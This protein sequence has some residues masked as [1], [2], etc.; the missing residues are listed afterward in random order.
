MSASFTQPYLNISDVDLVGIP[1]RSGL[2]QKA[3]LGGK[4]QVR[5]PSPFVYFF[6][7]LNL[8]WEFHG[9]ECVCSFFGF[10]RFSNANRPFLLASFFNAGEDKSRTGVISSQPGLISSGEKN[11]AHDCRYTSF[12]AINQALM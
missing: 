11:A 3:R 8:E 5:V 7:R 4:G 10:V 12:D 9:K 6:S 1:G 2:I